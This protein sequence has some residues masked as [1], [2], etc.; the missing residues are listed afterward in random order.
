VHTESGTCAT[1]AQKIT[2]ERGELLFT[3]AVENPYLNII[4]V[5]PNLDVRVGVSVVGP[6][7]NPRVR[8]FSEPDMSDMEKLSWLVLGRGSDGLGSTDTALLQ[9]AAIAL[10]AGEDRMASS[11]LMEQLGMT[12]FSMRQSD[13]ATRET[14]VTVGRQVSQRWYV[15]YERSVNA[16]T[17][18]WQLIY[19]VAQ[20]FTIRAQSGVENALDVIW[21]WRW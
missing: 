16:T 7:A 17:G 3:G 21:S 18:T 15:G 13:S 19:R 11:P 5:R 20:R 6:I 14:I 8:L 2:I 1:Y 4:A 9:S 10:L 12:Q